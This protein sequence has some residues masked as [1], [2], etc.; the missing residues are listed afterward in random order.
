MSNPFVGN[1]FFVLLHK[2]K[3]SFEQKY[4][5]GKVYDL[6]NGERFFSDLFTWILFWL[7]VLILSI[8]LRRLF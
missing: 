4:D 7:V 3:R 6:H 1:I 2:C 5:D 8:F